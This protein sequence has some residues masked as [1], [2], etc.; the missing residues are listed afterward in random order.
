MEDRIR[1]ARKLRLEAVAAGVSE[2]DVQLLADAMDDKAARAFG[3]VPERFAIVRNGRLAW[4][5]GR[6]PM[7]YLTSELDAALDV[8]LAASEGA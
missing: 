7:Y 8:L 6:G 4:L 1:A 5:G 3:A 2:R